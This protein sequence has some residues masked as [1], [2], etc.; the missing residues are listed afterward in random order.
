L[1]ERLAENRKVEDEVM[2]LGDTLAHSEKIL[3]SRIGV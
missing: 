1:E 3:A 2:M